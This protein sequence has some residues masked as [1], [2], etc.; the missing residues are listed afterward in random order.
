M[1]VTLRGVPL[2]ERI[3]VSGDIQTT[4]QLPCDPDNETAFY[5]L[6]FSDGTLILGSYDEERVYRFKP[7]IE[8][9]GITTIRRE[10]EHDVIELG[11]NVEWVAISSDRECACLVP[12]P[13]EPLPVLPGL[14]EDR[15]ETLAESVH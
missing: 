6:S 14:F 15:P 13:E 10:G 1:A 2:R 3:E 8:G 4:L 7:H 12:E 5:F 9:A 11:W